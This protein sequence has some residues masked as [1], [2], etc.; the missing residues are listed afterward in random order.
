VSELKDVA[1]VLARALA[2]QPQAVSVTESEHRGTTVVE[3]FVAPNDVGKMVGRQGRTI[4]A[5]RTL[6]SATAERLG[7]KATLE[8]RERR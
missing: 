2:D 4:A 3:V 6:V 1:D 8:V 5:L 7:K